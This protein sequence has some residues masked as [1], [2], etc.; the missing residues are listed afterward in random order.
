MTDLAIVSKIK[1]GKRIKQLRVARNWTGIQL[2]EFHG[3]SRTAITY[4]EQGRILPLMPI[5]KTC[6]AMGVLPSA[7]F[8]FDD[9]EFDEYIELISLIPSIGKEVYT[10]ED[11]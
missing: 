1:I 9:E 4:W 11:I 6:N 10:S 5:L 3:Y 8:E 7:L 2:A